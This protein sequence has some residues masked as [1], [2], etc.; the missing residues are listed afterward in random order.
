LPDGNALVV[1]LT[2]PNEDRTQLWVLSYPSG[3]LR[4]LTNDLSDYGAQLDIT[5]DGHMLVA[6]ENRLVSHIW[7]LSEGDTASAREITKGGILDSAVSPG[8]NGKLLIRSGNGKMQLINADG[9]ERT[10]F[11]PEASNLVSF[12]SCGDRYVVFDYYK[13]KLQLWR[14]DADGTNPI[15]LTDDVAGSTT[16]SPDGTWVLY[17]YG[18]ALYRIGINGG[19][20]KELVRT[21]TL[22]GG[23]ISP[24]GEWIAYDYQ[25]WE[26][27]PRV[28]IEVIPAEGGSAKR[29]FTLPVDAKGLRWSPDG[30][31]VHY[32]LTRMGATNVWEQELAR[33][34]HKG[35]NKRLNRSGKRPLSRA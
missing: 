7:Q 18:N 29:R 3:E 35:E 4:R 34:S 5:R 22:G 30:K 26:P 13:G 25:E 12:S 24:D 14:A 16:C 28:N 9:T 32:L 17:S 27:I 33:K 31:G 11:L 2:P 10:P 6:K 23:T 19:P 15:E 1:P 21:Q 8:P 20:A